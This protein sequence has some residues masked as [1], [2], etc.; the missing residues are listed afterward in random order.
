[1]WW[2][3]TFSNPL[4]SLMALGHTYVCMYMYACTCTYMYMY[5]HVHVCTD[6]GCLL[7]VMNQAQIKLSQ[8]DLLNEMGLL[9][10]DLH[11]RLNPRLKPRLT[12]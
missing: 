5:M 4:I 10:L 8:D 1:M 11:P 12:S 2:I 7:G 6:F 3:V 9:N